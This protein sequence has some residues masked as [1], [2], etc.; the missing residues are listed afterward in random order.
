MNVFVTLMSNYVL[1]NKLLICVRGI[2][3]LVV[4]HHHLLVDFWILDLRKGGK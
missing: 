4:I 3:S 2:Y 1:Y